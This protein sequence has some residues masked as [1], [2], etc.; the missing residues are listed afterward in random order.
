M[1]DGASLRH[2]YGIS[3]MWLVLMLSLELRTLDLLFAVRISR[4]GFCASILTHEK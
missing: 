3:G 2:Q 4:L 1:V